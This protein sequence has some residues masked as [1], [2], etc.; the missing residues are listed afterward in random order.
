MKPASYLT[1]TITQLS[2]QT[3]LYAIALFLFYSCLAGCAPSPPFTLTIAHL[4]DTHSHLESE[5]IDLLLGGEKTR[6]LIGG[7]PVIASKVQQL[8][9]DNSNFLLLH[10]GDALSGT[11]YYSLFK[12]EAEARLMNMLPFDG[13]VIGNHEF[14]DGN[15]V[16]ATFLQTL[17]APAISANIIVAAD[18]PL[19]SLLKP[20]LLYTIDGQQ[21]GI[22]GIT[23]AKKTKES[24]RPAPSVSFSDEVATTKHMVSLLQKQGIN[25]IIVLSHYGYDNDLALASAVSGVDVIIG[26]DSHSLLGDFTPFGLTSSGPYPSQTVSATNEPVCVVQAWQYGRAIGRLD[27][28]FDGE[29]M[30]TSC[31]GETTLLLQDSFTRKNSAGKRVEIEGEARQAVYQQLKETKL[32]EIIVPDPSVSQLLH[33]YAG[34]IEPLKQQPIGEAKEALIH[35]RIPGVPYNGAALPLGSNVAPLVA[36]SFYELSLRADAAITNAG[37]VRTNI[38]QGTITVNTAYTLLPFS[39]TLVE[40]TMS[41]KQIHDV[42][43]DAVDTAIHGKSSGAFPYAYGLR[44]IVT[45][46]AKKGKRVGAMEIKNRTTGDWSALDDARQ[47]VI[48]TNSYIASGKDGYTTFQKVKES[49]GMVDTYLDYA[50]SFM[51]YVKK[52]NKA[53]RYVVKLD[54]KEHPIK[55]FAP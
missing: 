4:N 31:D 29:G 6:T 18:D 3:L 54:E 26:G 9:Q 39:N 22:I 43:E 52:R 42:L 13:F 24:S 25:K 12:G 44:Y 47:Y 41:G 11:I 55:S 23:V 2:K 16:L 19:S 14:D 34:K 48:V 53:G 46:Q 49:G 28:H 35:T 1:N 21:I 17:K 33:E 36:K 27:I 37:G 45:S 30:V 50:M 5:P 32:A 51:E 8:K 20:Y 7:F 40:F 15:G 10:G 38:D